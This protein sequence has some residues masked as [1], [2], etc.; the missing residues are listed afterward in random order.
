MGVNVLHHM[1]RLIIGNQCF[2]ALDAC[3]YLY[4]YIYTAGGGGGGG[5]CM[6]SRGY[7]F[8]LVSR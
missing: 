1:I 8:V 6:R 2:I 7:A 3:D 5:A 4:I